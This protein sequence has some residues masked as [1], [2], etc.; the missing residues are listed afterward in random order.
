[1]AIFDL[2][3]FNYRKVIKLAPDAFVT[4]NGAFG[5]RVVSPIND[6]AGQTI[7]IQGGVVSINVTSA[8][9]PP[10][11]GRAKIQIV[12]PEYT[13]F[14]TKSTN[15]SSGYWI[16]LPSGVKIPYF[17][18]MMEVQVF[19]K[20]RF[21]YN[22]G[23]GSNTQS[24][25]PLVSSGQN[26][27]PVYYRAFW[28]FIT[29]ITE[30][31]NAGLTTLS[32]QCSDMLTWWKY[33]KLTISPNEYTAIFNSGNL[34]ANAFPTIFRNRNPWQ[35][36]TQLLYETQWLSL[37]KNATFNFAYP[38]LS[39]IATLPYMDGVPSSVIG[40]LAVKM[41]EYWHE[42]YNFYN[43]QM[44][45]EMFGLT[46][47]VSDK[48][49]Q[50]LKQSVLEGLDTAT[51]GY[52]TTLDPD[53]SLDY[54]LLARVM[55]FGDFNLFGMGAESLELTKLDIAQKVCDMTQMEFYEDLNGS[56]VF[57]PPFYNL[58]V[59]KG[60][61]PFY[62]VD[63]KDIINYSSSTNTDH[64]VTFLELTAPQLQQIPG[65]LPMIGF[66]IDWELMLR[67]GM[68]YQRGHCSYGNDVKSLSLIAAAEMARI[69]AEATTGHVS[70]P[71]RPEIRLG[72][73]VYIT[74]KDSL[75][76]Y[77]RNIS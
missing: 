43:E 17:L 42:R 52:N 49:L 68:R 34:A 41:S 76:L 55:P 48:S 10:A 47:A 69:N 31:Y 38:K 19:M 65:D 27:A 2:N 22:N 75:F 9:S 15:S 40:A 64:I 37:D 1:M 21:L 12:A 44:K 14:H 57:K 18:P 45:V 77:F 8:I 20:G 67:Y 73:P 36:I 24:S 51:K 50:N 74:H 35:I 33:Q 39:A 60:D 13:G 66:H 70:I 53:I 32:L 61:V 59:T 71:L 58:D 46:K 6:E 29:E 30:D 23:S 28:G 63:P 11:S 3:D 16:T 54:N 72:Y 56:I 7:D 26:N 25:M 4:I 5:G 62:V